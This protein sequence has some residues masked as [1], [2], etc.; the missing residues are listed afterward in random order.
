MPG[1]APGRKTTADSATW[2]I[3]KTVPEMNLGKVAR[4]ITFAANELCPEFSSFSFFPPFCGIFFSWS[5][6]VSGILSF[7]LQPTQRNGC[8]SSVPCLPKS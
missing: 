2:E 7:S 1:L 6:Q 3:Q 8:F 5:F 4:R